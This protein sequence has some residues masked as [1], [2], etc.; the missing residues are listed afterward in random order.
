M[1]SKTERNKTGSSS[2]QTGGVKAA[3]SIISVNLHIIGN[4]SSDGEMQIDGRIEGDITS[5]SLTVGE[6]ASIDGEIVADD[7]EIRGAVSGRIRA[8]TIKLAKTAKVVGDIC[9]EVLSIEPGACIEGQLT[10]TAR[11]EA[12]DREVPPPAG[13]TAAPAAR[14]VSGGEAAATVQEVAG[15]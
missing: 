14:P 2:S 10:R 15:R 4:L 12:A 8:G 9:H 1:F 7:V 13:V 5:Q 6:R 11:M 3:P